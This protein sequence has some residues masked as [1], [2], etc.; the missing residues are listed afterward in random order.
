MHYRTA[1][2][3]SV[4]VLTAAC[5][6][7]DSVTGPDLTLPSG[8]M[9]ARI[10]GTAWQ[11]TAALSVAYAGGVLAFAGS[12]ASQ[13]TVGVGLIP[14]GPGTCAIGPNQPTNANV[15][16]GAI[17]SWG[18]TSGQGSGSITLTSFTQ[19][20]AKGTFEF[21]APAVPNTG[22]TGTKVVTLGTFDVKF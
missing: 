3:A 11:A 21:T 8:S 17:G 1:L 18:A 4:L 14:T 13:T 19:N 16:T 2:T 10:D 20:S 12:D 7:G 9:S 6:S 5:S 15:T 22:A